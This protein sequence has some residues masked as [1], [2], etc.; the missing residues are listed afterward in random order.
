MSFFARNWPIRAGGRGWLLAAAAAAALLAVLSVVDAQVSHFGQ[1]LPE[2]ALIA[3]GWFTR[4]GESDWILV[5]S[6]IVLVAAA[7]GARY[8]SSTTLRRAL[9]QL[10]GIAGFIFVGVG[11]PGLFTAIVKRIIGRGRPEGSETAAPFDFQVMSWGD[12]VY[13]SFPSGHA[14]TAFALCFVVS[15]LRPR[16]FPAML[17]F[18]ALI[19]LSR[20]VL[21]AHFPT[22]VLAGALAGTLGAY[23]VRNVFARRGWVFR[24]ASDG[25]VVMRPLSAIRR[26]LN[27]RGRG[28]SPRR[29]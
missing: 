24:Y 17:M 28:L 14:T 20:I 19:A 3:F 15:F 16:W 23:L 6:A 27:R 13:Q 9:A 5:P 4:L 12:W 2:P 7:A 25:S 10:T 26:L 1:S 11:L 22:D 29:P 21:G 8:A 18:A